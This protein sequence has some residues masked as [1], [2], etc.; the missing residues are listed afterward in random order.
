MWVLSPMLPAEQLLC[1]SGI[2]LSSV[3]MFQFLPG[4]LA[5]GLQELLRVPSHSTHKKNP[6]GLAF[7]PHLQ[8][9]LLPLVLGP[10]ALQTKPFVHQY[11]YHQL[12]GFCVFMYTI[13]LLKNFPLYPI[14]LSNCSSENISSQ[15]LFLCAPM[16]LFI[17]STK[18][19]YANV[20]QSSAYLTIFQLTA[21]SLRVV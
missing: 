12:V 7:C 13:P 9:Q 14:Y 16:M 19:T 4:T 3:C 17:I 11:I 18:H 6:L 15:K 20:F 21:Y 2:C 8:L 10:T 5:M 1:E